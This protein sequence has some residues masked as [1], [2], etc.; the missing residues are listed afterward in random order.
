MENNNPRILMVFG[1]A[2]PMPVGGAEIQGTRLCR[3]LNAMNVQ[4]RIISWGKFW[5]KRKGEFRGLSFTR[6]STPLDLLID[7]PSLFPRKKKA[8]PSSF[9]I[10]YDDNKEVTSEVRGK[11]WVGMILRYNLFYISALIHLWLRKDKFDI[12]HV[13]M[14]EWP[15]WVGVKLG[16]RL[17]KPVVIKDSTMNGIRNILRYPHGLRKQKEIVSYAHFVAMTNAI[18]KN[19]LEAGVPDHRVTMIPNG[20][21]VAELMPR[22]RTWSG[23][24]LFVGNLTQQPAKGIDILLQSWRQ[25][26]NEHPSASLHIVGEGNLELYRQYCIETGISHAVKF[27]GKQQVLPSTFYQHDVF[28]LPSR[29]EGMSNALMEA[30]MTGMPVV[31]TEVSGSQDL[32]TNGYSGLLVRT[33]DHKAL[34][35]ALL[36]MLNVPQKALEMG[37]KGYQSVCQK[38]DMIRVAADYKA[39]YAKILS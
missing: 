35:G 15:A 30:M 36:N 9:K 31:A 13:H 16:R 22:D 34:S 27:Y 10:V 28:V 39:L 14:M 2:P 11:V 37:Q 25:V 20:I 1:T 29:R 12:I 19:F 6:V 3:Q 21:D 7:I 26:I 23:S 33:G 17:K 4:T 18:K 5:F 32:I 24:V 8:Q 38:C